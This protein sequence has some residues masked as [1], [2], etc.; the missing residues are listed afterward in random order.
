M[1]YIADEKRLLVRAGVGWPPGIVGKASIGT[2]LAS[3]AD[4]AL[5]SGKPVISNHLENE[6]RF[7]TP[8]LL[9]QQG[10]RR[11]MNVILQG[12]GSP[13]GVLEVDSRSE[14]EFVPHDL[15]FL[16][17]AANIV[18]MAIERQ[19]HEQNLKLALDRQRLLMRELNHR[20]KNSL[21]I[22]S[23]ILSL[24]A[25]ANA[26]DES[27]QRHLQEASSRVATVARAHDRLYKT[28]DVE[29]LEIGTYIKEV[30]ADLPT[31]T[32]TSIVF[33]RR[34]AQELVLAPHPRWRPPVGLE[35]PLQ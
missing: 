4:F 7:R 2:D 13:F 15:A 26:D 23:S 1:Q 31:V 16:Q 24:Q 27:L 18:G 5:R 20:V 34:P 14:G 29:Q 35:N 19:R 22:V 17:G 21:A 11:A 10:V 6:E 28:N 33:R 8:E 9:V 30:C 25:R 3:P 12:D 32:G